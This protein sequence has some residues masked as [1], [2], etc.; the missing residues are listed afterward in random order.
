MMGPAGLQDTGVPWLH[1]W[2]ALLP[3]AHHV[4]CLSPHFSTCL[5]GGGQDISLTALL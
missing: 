2:V 4:T 1:R 3:G 5:S